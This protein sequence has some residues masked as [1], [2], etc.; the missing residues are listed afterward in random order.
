MCCC[1]AVSWYI[2]FLTGDDV[3]GI[4]FFAPS[5]SGGF[6]CRGNL[7][8]VVCGSDL[9]GPSQ[10]AKYA[11]SRCLTSQKVTKY[12]IVLEIVCVSKCCGCDLC[13]RLC[14]ACFARKR[15]LRPASAAELAPPTFSHHV[16]PQTSSHT[17][18]A[19]SRLVSLSPLPPTPTSILAVI[20]S[21]LHHSLTNSGSDKSTASDDSITR[22]LSAGASPFNPSPRLFIPSTAKSRPTHIL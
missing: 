21:L 11:I 9:Y 10:V 6:R 2:L 1:I 16:R 8:W 19:L 14:R 17:A 13:S 12:G 18:A 5:D 20:H 22:P 15:R 7:S 4:S 3:D